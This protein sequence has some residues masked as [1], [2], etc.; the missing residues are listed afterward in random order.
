MATLTRLTS[1]YATYPAKKI[2]RLTHPKV[3]VLKLTPIRYMD[4]VPVSSV[5]FP[6]YTKDSFKTYSV[7]GIKEKLIQQRGKLGFNV[8]PFCKINSKKKF[9]SW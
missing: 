3:N 5:R 6:E 1:F 8:W 4:K 7:T 9:T 2:T